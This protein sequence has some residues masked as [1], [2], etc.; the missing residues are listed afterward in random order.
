[1]ALGNGEDKMRR[2]FFSTVAGDI[3]HFVAAVFAMFTIG[4]PVLAGSGTPNHPPT[5]IDDSQLQVLT[6]KFGGAQVL[7]TTRTIPHWAGSTLDPHNGIT[8]GYN[9][10]G[11][12]PKSCLV[13]NCSIT[14]EVDI[15]PLTFNVDGMT[16]SGSDV[17]AAALD[18][19]QFT[20]NDYG[21]T[22]FATTG[23][24]G[25]SPR[26]PGGV[27]SQSDAGLPLQL[28]DAIMR[29]QFNQTGAYSS[30]HLKL[31]PNVLPPVTIDVPDI[32]GILF[33]SDRGVV[34]P[35]VDT[36]FLGAQLQNLLTTADPTHLTLYLSDDLAGFFRR[37]NAVFCCL[38]GFHAVTAAGINDLGSGH[39][40]GNAPVHTFAWVTWLSPGIYAGPNGTRFWNFQDMNTLSH[41]IAEWANDPF[42]SNF[43]EPWFAPGFGCSPFL[44]TGDAVNTVGFAVGTNTFRQGPNP[45][46]TQSADGFYHPQDEVF[47][48]WF[49]R[50]APN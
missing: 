21:S 7:P 30:Y 40:G 10:V 20:L 17:L 23:P 6:M 45:D 31:H 26:G 8:Y 16:F 9:I 38:L 18:S 3:V 37:G 1:M 42:G 11:A 28:Q 46:G 47:I 36:R 39:S 33:V 15:V 32:H 4:T 29:A 5:P 12:D 27:L 41:E 34:F 43:V 19:P 50:V 2:M 22:P 49:M 13:Q 44:E 14:I 48:P 35:A 24:F 25:V